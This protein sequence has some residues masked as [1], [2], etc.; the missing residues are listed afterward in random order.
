MSLQQ[1]YSSPSGRFGRRLPATASVRAADELLRRLEPSTSDRI[2]SPYGESRLIP[3][4]LGV[5]FSGYIQANRAFIPNYGDRWRNGEAISTAFV[6]SAVNQIVSR[7]FVKK[8]QMRWTER[9]GHHLLQIRTR[10]L[11]GE[12]RGTL[13]RWNP[14]MEA[15]A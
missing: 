5:G 7:R 15:V 3:R 10:V 14:G 8:Q 4:A 1:V 6:E 13:E 9:G 11:N 12:W 2:R